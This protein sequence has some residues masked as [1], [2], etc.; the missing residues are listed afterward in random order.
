MAGLCEGGNEP[1]G[2][3]KPFVR[4]GTILS[5][6]S[7]MLTNWALYQGH[8]PKTLAPTVPRCVRNGS[9]SKLLSCGYHCLEPLADPELRSGVGS[10]PAWADY[11]VA[12]HLANRR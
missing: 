12:F 8:T 5:C 11:Q 1:S 2:S 9:F 10:I 3:L 7:N 4:S 6:T